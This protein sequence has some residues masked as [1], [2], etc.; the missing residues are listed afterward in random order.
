[1]FPEQAYLIRW[2]IMVM[3]P[4]LLWWLQKRAREV[5]TP[6]QKELIEK[7]GPLKLL[8]RQAFLVIGLGLIL[9]G[10]LAVPWV[11][12]EIREGRYRNHS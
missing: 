8:V 4:V 5:P 9:Y 10:V 2:L 6:E 1:M 12:E 7:H 11:W 3:G